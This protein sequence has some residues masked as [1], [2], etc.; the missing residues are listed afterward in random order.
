MNLL[1]K[2]D[3]LVRPCKGVPGYRAKLG[4]KVRHI[5]V[6]STAAHGR[7]I[8]LLLGCGRRLGAAGHE[9][10]PGVDAGELVGGV[11]QP[12]DGLHTQEGACEVADAAGQS[13]GGGRGRPL[14]PAVLLRGPL[15]LLGHPRCLRS[16][17]EV[18]CKGVGELIV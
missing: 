13:V 16:I 4:D 15:C 14:A 17:A 6:G 8:N 5:S 2:G 11:Y 18:F 7:L 3:Q 10:Q 1:G 9:P 12:A